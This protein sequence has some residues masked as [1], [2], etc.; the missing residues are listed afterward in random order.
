M[1]NHSTFCNDLEL[2]AFQTSTVCADSAELR[3][4][5]DLI[6]GN[7]LRRLDAN[8]VVV[9]LEEEGTFMLRIPA[10]N[11]AFALLI[12]DANAAIPCEIRLDKNRSRVIGLMELK[13]WKWGEDEMNYPSSTSTMSNTIGGVNFDSAM[14]N[15]D[16][17]NDIPR[18]TLGVEELDGRGVELTG[19]WRAVNLGP[20]EQEIAE[21]AKRMTPFVIQSI[22]PEHVALG[23]H[24]DD[25][26]EFS[27][28]RASE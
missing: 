26:P 8:V 6:V 21:F 7:N 14:L 13:Y 16:L 9:S 1:K 25:I 3:A 24:I 15:G 17:E 23:H 4:L 19:G 28:T 12:G 5:H 11:H 20:N 10:S 18:S 27:C 22:S 2:E